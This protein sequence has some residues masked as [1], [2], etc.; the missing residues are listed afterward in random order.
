MAFRFFCFLVALL[1]FAPLA[2]GKGTGY[3]ATSNPGI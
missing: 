3:A 1:C 2:S